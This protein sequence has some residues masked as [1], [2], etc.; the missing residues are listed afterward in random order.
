M[1]QAVSVIKRMELTSPSTGIVMLNSRNP[2]TVESQSQ[3]FQN[4]VAMLV[5]GSREQIHE[6]FDVITLERMQDVTFVVS[7]QRNQTRA[8]GLWHV[9]HALGPDIDLACSGL[10][11]VPTRDVMARTTSPPPTQCPT[12]TRCRA[13]SVEPSFVHHCDLT[14]AVGDHISWRNGPKVSPQL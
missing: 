1:K 6:A 14:S 3:Y 7:D 8:D 4:L 5:P 11:Q 9:R 2:E 13:P 10:H 12:A